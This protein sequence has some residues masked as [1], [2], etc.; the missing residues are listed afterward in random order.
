MSELI[1][2][3]N[4]SCSKSNCV[5]NILADSGKKFITVNYIQNPLNENEIR[6]LLKKLNLYA[7]QIIR[8]NE[9][10][11]LPYQNQSLSEEEC[12]TLLVMYPSLMQRPIVVNG[13]KAIIARP[14]E[15]VL[16]IV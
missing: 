13:Q 12:V 5:Y 1:L 11:F 2:Y 8:Q 15:L 9:P 16:T 7:I 6:V 14:P 10:E 4:N 3:H